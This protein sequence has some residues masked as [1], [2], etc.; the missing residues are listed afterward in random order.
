M[1]LQA[2]IIC[3]YMINKIDK[4]SH[5]TVAVVPA[6]AWYF[7]QGLIKALVISVVTYSLPRANSRYSSVKLS[8]CFSAS[9]RLSLKGT[10]FS[11]L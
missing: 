7:L 5:G 11:G 3:Y 4:F 2:V 9:L 10:Y 8:L 6:H 1:A